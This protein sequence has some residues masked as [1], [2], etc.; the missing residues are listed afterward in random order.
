VT[1]KYLEKVGFKSTN[2]RYILG[3]LKF[4]GFVDAGG[5]PTKLWPAYRNRNS[6]GKALAAAIRQ[7]YSDLFKTYPDANRKDGEAL[8]NYFSAHTKVAESTLGLIVGTF[9]MLCAADVEGPA[10]AL[11]E[12]EEDTEIA[13]QSR[14]GL[15]TPK[16]SASHE[17]S[18]SHGPTIN[19]NIQLQL[20]ATDDGAIY[21]KLFAALKKH[22]VR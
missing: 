21:D 2:D 3:L 10:P 12:E 4:L 11:E 17:S 14:R 9:K 6:G 8:R 15:K 13:A 18:G 1:I 20:P 5:V 7:S 19:I 22:L 16:G